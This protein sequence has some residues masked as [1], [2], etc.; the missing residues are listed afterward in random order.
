MLTKLA[1]D[2]NGV[3]LSGNFYGW[4]LLGSVSIIFIVSCFFTDI[5]T[6][7]LLCLLLGDLVN[8]VLILIASV[9]AFLFQREKRNAPSR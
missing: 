4:S 8:F 6:A 7:F 9:M 5:E 2:Y 3:M 1:K